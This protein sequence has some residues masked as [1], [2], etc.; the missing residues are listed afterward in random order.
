MIKQR[1][2]LDYIRTPRIMPYAVH[3]PSKLD[4]NGEYICYREP[5]EKDQDILQLS[6][7]GQLIGTTGNDGD[8]MNRMTTVNGG[9]R[10]VCKTI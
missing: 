5:Y 1:D 2:D 10:E 7:H 4:P 3:A 8:T 6:S 9:I